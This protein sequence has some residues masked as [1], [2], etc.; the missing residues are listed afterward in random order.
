MTAG[1][2]TRTLAQKLGIK[3]NTSLCILNNPTTYKKTLGELPEGVKVSNKIGET[4]DVIH[5]FTNE[6]N[7]LE[8]IFPTL[9]SHLNPDGMLWISWP[10]L[11]RQVQDKRVRV[12]LTENTIRDIGLAN[13]LAPVKVISFDE[14]WSGLK[15]IL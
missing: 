15:F 1:Y 8:R 12:D 13:G 11:H 5:Y 6:R 2:S 4:Y 3:P 10:K 7:D 14:V 9:K